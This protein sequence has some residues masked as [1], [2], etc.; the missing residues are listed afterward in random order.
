MARPVETSIDEDVLVKHS[1]LVMHEVIWVAIIPGGNTLL[2]KP[3]D[4]GAFGIPLAVVGYYANF[5]SALV[6][7]QNRVGDLVARD[8]EYADVHTM[9]AVLQMLKQLG[10]RGRLVSKIAA[11]TSLTGLVR[12]KRIA[13]HLLVREEQDLI[14]HARGGGA[15]L[16]GRAIRQPHTL[17]SKAVPHVAE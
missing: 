3:G 14:M 13:R 12:Q 1:K 15:R 6:C 9:L 17:R 11:R 16:H 8:G 5:D 2:S 7:S 10:E 4:V